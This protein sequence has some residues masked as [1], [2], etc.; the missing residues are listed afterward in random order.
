MSYSIVFLDADG[1]L[2]DFEHAERHA[3]ESA[4]GDLGVAYRADHLA[5]YKEVN[6]EMW[7]RLERGEVNQ[8][9]MRTERF[10]LFCERAA[11]EADPALM[12]SSYLLHLSEAD[13]L[14][15][16]ALE[17]VAALSGIATLSLITNGLK[18]V[19]R[20]RLSRSPIT[21][22]FAD[23][24]ISEEVGSQ[25][26]SPQIFEVALQ[27]LGASDRSS[28]IMVGD[29]LSSDIAGG[30]NAGIATCWYNPNGE[31]APRG[32]EPDYSVASLSEIPSMV[33]RG[34]R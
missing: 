22:Y 27:R 34:E 20:G 30:R 25:K 1:T 26:P 32:S 24:V 14:L 5:L 9:F 13:F 28:A 33:R 6:G 15:D 23:V 7:K 16:G 18:D 4:F 31:V 11:L 19:Q 2:F 29:S 17:T 10:R 12:S 3:L 21:A 8:E